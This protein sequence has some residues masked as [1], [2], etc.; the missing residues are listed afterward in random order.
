[1]VKELVLVRESLGKRPMEIKQMI[2]DLIEENVVVRKIL[3]ISISMKNL[4]I[5]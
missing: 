4:C 1:V 3:S 2:N 5:F